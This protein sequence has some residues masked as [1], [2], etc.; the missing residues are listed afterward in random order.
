MMELSL[1]LLICLIYIIA[2]RLWNL[3]TQSLLVNLYSNASRKEV[4]FSFFNVSE[5]RGKI[6]ED[7]ICIVDFILLTKTQTSKI[8]TH[9]K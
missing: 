9:V 7:M 5:F 8:Y 4:C 3:L 2:I 1:E 6:D